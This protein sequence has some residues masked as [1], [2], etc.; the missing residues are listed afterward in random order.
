MFI[1]QKKL[2]LILLI[3]LPFTLF[4]QVPVTAT[5]SAKETHHA[6]PIRVGMINCDTGRGWHCSMYL[7]AF[8]PGGR[9]VIYNQGIGDWEF[10]R[11]SAEIL[12]LIKKMVETGKS[13]GPVNQM[14][15]A[16]AIADAAD[17]AIKAGATQPFE[18]VKPFPDINL[19]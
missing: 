19:K 6:K 8:G 18:T 2:I 10:S 4:A 9:G 3:L 13:Q 15:E 12:R 11:G 5:D 17:A 16:V 14:I 7:S 1:L